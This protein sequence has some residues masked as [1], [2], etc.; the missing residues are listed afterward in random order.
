MNLLTIVIS[1][2]FRAERTGRS[3]LK[4]A[5]TADFL[6]VSEDIWPNLV[7]FSNSQIS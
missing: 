4:K 3:A 1:S 5:F 7:A 2:I 6:C